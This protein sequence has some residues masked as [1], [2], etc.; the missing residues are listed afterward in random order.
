MVCTATLYNYIEAQLLGVRNIDF[1]EKTG[2]RVKHKA[3]HKFKRMLTAAVSTTGLS[4][5]TIA[6]SSAISS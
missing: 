4:A 6:E 3:N 5:S 1:L 2:R